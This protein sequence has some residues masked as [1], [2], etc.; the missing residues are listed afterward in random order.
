MR[1]RTTKVFITGDGKEW[2][3]QDE[4]AAHEARLLREAPEAIVAGKTVEDIERALEGYDR[5][6][7]DAIE[8]LGRKCAQAR[9][10]RGERKRHRGERVPDPVPL[11]PAIVGS[12]SERKDVS[13]EGASATL[14]MQVI[15]TPTVAVVDA[16]AA[17]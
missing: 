13:I 16:T 6:L 1:T 17:E 11:D 7:A 14:A 5:V 3:D 4:A 9:L 8:A 15:T 12:G 10:D 2:I